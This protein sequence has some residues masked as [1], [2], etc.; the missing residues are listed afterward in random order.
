MDG[1]AGPRPAARAGE[2]EDKIAAKRPDTKEGGREEEKSRLGIAIDSRRADRLRS[3][4]T[5]I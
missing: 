4:K 3:K 2:A 5:V 1:W